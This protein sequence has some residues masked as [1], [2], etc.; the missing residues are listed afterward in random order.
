MMVIT[1]FPQVKPG[2]IV[3]RVKGSTITINGEAFN[4]SGIPEGYRLPAG[5]TGSE[6]FTPGTFIE[7]AN[8]EFLFSLILPVSWD[9]PPAIMSPDTPT[10]IRVE[11]GTAQ[12]PST[13]P[14][15]KKENGSF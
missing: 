6:H 5:A 8:G 4:L 15:E 14:E 13:E 2:T 7:R 11:K 10:V 9:S 12:F 3:A 1:L